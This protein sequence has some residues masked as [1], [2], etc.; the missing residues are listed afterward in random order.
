MERKGS[1][2]QEVAAIAITSNSILIIIRKERRV[3]AINALLLESRSSDITEKES[4]KAKVRK[5][6]CTAHKL[7]AAFLFF[8]AFNMSL[9]FMFNSPLKGELLLFPLFNY[10]SIKIINSGG[11]KGKFCVFGS[12][13]F[14][15]RLLPVAGKA[16]SL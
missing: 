3:K 9:L 14:P 11:K 16:V 1:I 4:D 12:V 8:L 5:N 15:R 7:D 13:G 6:I 2:L 10:N